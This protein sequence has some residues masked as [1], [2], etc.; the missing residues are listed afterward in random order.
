MFKWF[1]RNK[2]AEQANDKH[3]SANNVVDTIDRFFNINDVNIAEDLSEPQ[4]EEDCSYD[5]VVSQEL[6]SD[7]SKNVVG[8]LMV[9]VEPLVKNGSYVK[10]KQP[11][12]RYRDS[13]LRGED[14][15]IIT[16]KYNGYFFFNSLFDYS[17]T[18]EIG[19]VIC[20]T[21]LS[22]EELV[23][24][25]YQTSYYIG[26]DVFTGEKTIKWQQ[27]F[28]ISPDS[29][30]RDGV[31]EGVEFGKRNVVIIYSVQNNKAVLRLH[32]GKNL[33]KGSVKINIAGGDKIQLL[34]SNQESISY[35]V[36]SS[37]KLNDYI[38]E[39]CIPLSSSDIEK[40]K[41][42]PIVG[43]R[44]SKNNSDISVDY[45]INIDKKVWAIIYDDYVT[46]YLAAL[47]EC[48]IDWKAQSSTKEQKDTERNNEE[49]FVY[50]MHD[51][52]NNAY[53][54]GISNNPHY[55]EHTLQSEKPF[56]ELLGSKQFPTRKI[57]AAFESALHDAY[58][59]KHIRGEWFFLDADDVNNVLESLK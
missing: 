10:S 23:Q 38:K 52:T 4:I 42:Y 32:T 34:L 44:I 39:C 26:R 31:W 33:E 40:L 14:W 43:I 35:I 54:I 20:S 59:D 53:K 11:I 13:L 15:G 7:S 3:T 25:K 27:V 37:T 57:A 49:C 56:I 46:K 47:E 29:G 19:S 41:E 50:L 58:G 2:C 12:L 5:Y 9:H 1:K 21:F 22:I 16:A 6:F 18:P 30:F 55:R 48:E 8:G 24:N 51:T 45:Y 36:S 28:G 17:R